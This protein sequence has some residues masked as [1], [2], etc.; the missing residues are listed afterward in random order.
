MGTAHLQQFKLAVSQGL[1]GLLT[2]GG[3][4]EAALELSPPS[5]PEF[6]VSIQTSNPG[7]MA[8]TGGGCL[9]Q[10]QVE[11]NSCFRFEFQPVFV[12]LN[13]SALRF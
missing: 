6:S 4:H 8:L 2:L 12:A 9:I 3:W 13:K 10:T 1:K 5:P 11:S 7:G